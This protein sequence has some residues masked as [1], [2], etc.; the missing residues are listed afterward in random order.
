MTTNKQTIHYTLTDE[1]PSLA[2]CSLLPIVRTFTEAAG[3]KV[4]ITDI[5]LAGRILSHFPDSLEPEQQVPD[6][7]SELGELATRS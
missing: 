5:S 1:A 7:L 6:A 2:T 4:K 3:I